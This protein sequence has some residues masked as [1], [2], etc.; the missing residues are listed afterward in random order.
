MLEALGNIGDF[1]GGIAVIATLLYL[2]IQVRQNTRLL[3]AQALSTNAQVGVA[4][5]NL[6]GTDPAAARVFQLGLESFLDLSEAERRQ[7]INLLRAQF[8]GYQ[9]SYQQFEGGIIEEDAWGQHRKSAVRALSL[10]HV[11]E[12]W[13]HR[14]SV[15]APAFVAALDDA[16]R[17]EAG[18]LAGDV[19][20]AMAAK[21][22]RSPSR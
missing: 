14:K 11:A 1:L 9:H 17:G 15:F 21:A 13:A 16:P 12:W 19:I 20:D 3:R 8:T 18:L 6:L 7:F 22:E 4:F 2:A 5:N 10:P